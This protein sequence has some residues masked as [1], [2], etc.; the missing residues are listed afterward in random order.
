[1]EQPQTAQALPIEPH[2]CQVLMYENQ[3]RM[4]RQMRA[5][6]H[7]LLQMSI[8]RLAH[9]AAQFSTMHAYTVSNSA[10]DLPQ[11]QPEYLVAGP[12]K[13]VVPVVKHAESSN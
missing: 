12:A 10:H 4:T 9:N 5:S 8:P 7:C 13:T 3:S 2:F 6:A 1:M 11:M